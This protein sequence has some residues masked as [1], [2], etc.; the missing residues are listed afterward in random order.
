[1]CFPPFCSPAQNVLGC[2]GLKSGAAFVVAVNTFYGLALVVL[3][4]VLYANLPTDAQP[5]TGGLAPQALTAPATA[6]TSTLMSSWVLQL[7]DMDLS[8]GHGLLGLDDKTNVLAGLI[9]GLIVLIACGLM[10]YKL[11]NPGSSLGMA[12]RWYVAILNLE[13]L[14]YIGLTMVKL[15]KLCKIQESYFSKL[16]LDCN[17]LRY[18]YL[19]RALVFIVAAALATWVF[20][21]FS[22]LLSFGNQ[23]LDHPAFADELDLFDA[24]PTVVAKPVSGYQQDRFSSFRTTGS[25]SFARAGAP[26][27]GSFQGGSVLP[28]SSVRAGGGSVRPG[29]SMRPASFA[30]SPMGPTTSYNI[31][32]AARGSSAGSSPNSELHSLIRPPVAVY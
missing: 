4:S 9:Y 16:P 18:L 28:A 15:P 29:T 6:G 14:I 21:S 26:A 23:V 24:A 12:S 31:G 13:I 11:Q 25:Q 2:I 27:T 22:Y 32:S 1:M 8:W 20:S 5:A 3:H 17:F 19:Q 30:P 7:A 10:F